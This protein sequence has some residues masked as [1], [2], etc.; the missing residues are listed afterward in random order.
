MANA[1]HRIKNLLSDALHTSDQFCRAHEFSPPSFFFIG[2][3]NEF[4]DALFV[5]FTSCRAI[6][7]ALPL[8]IN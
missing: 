7:S 8:E 5:S 3:A 6:F 4:G 2:A 1:F